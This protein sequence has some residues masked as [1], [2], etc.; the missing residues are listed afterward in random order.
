M[1][2]RSYIAEW[3]Q[4]AP[5]QNED[6]VE[7]DLV[8][9]RA[10]V[11][12]YRDEHL[13]RTLAFRGGTA[14]HKLFLVPAARY[15]EDIDFV[16]IIAGP[17]G[18]TLDRL[19][20]V[21]DPWLGKPDYEAT[22]AGAHLYYRFESESN[23]GVSQR[24]KVEINTREHAA[25]YPLEACPFNV[26]TRWFDGECEVSSY[27]L[28]ELLGTKL[29]ALFQRNKGRDLFD[30]DYALRMKP[31]DCSKVVGAFV[32]YTALQN[33]KITSRQFR[34]NLAEKQKDLLFGRDV[35]PL[36]RPGVAYDIADALRRIDS[37]L[38]ALLDQAWKAHGGAA[39]S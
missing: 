8:L 5:W 9:S 13:R 1:I 36:L 28:E 3:H 15:S 11:E 37:Q 27:C 35:L 29:R 18:K 25:G 39:T 12:I 19:H 31:L 23:P 22:R 30:L 14:I 21:L 10:I 38:I 2:P 16:Q 32:H 33:R 6:H 34:N 4:H 26:K 17:I 20:A 24:V 7:Q